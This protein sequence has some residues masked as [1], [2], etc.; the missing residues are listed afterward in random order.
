MSGFGLVDFLKRW[1]PAL[2]LVILTYNPLKYSYY[3]WV[4]EG[5]D[6]SLPIKVLV[7][8]VLLIGYGIYLSA[9]WKSMGMFGMLIV[10][11][12]F[13]VLLW[14]FY[15]LGWIKPDDPSDFAWISIVI[16]ATVLA[17][18][19]SWSGIWRRLTGQV[20]VD[21]AGDIDHGH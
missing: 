18:G 8:L 3:H 10:I 7:G 11:I 1:I 17:V 9:T 13:L 20:T 5:D 14:V 2:I 19:M 4:M 16:L 21:D 15:S 12:F 6:G